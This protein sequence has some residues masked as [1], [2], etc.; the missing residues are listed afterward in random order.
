MPCSKSEV[1]EKLAESSSLKKTEVA[2]VVNG[3]LDLIQ[4]SVKKG[5]RVTLVGCAPGLRAARVSHRRAVAFPW[6]RPGLARRRRVAQPF[7]RVAAVA[8][9]RLPPRA[10]RA[11]ARLAFRF[12]GREPASRPLLVV[13]IR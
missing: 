3:L 10:P 6:P 1:I 5:E 7:A 4:E 13:G 11:G 2:A 9:R 8:T 12:A